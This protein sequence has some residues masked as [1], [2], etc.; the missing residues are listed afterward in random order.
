VRFAVPL[1]AVGG[2]LLRLWGLTR[3]SIWVDEQFTLKFAGMEHPLTWE[4]VLVNLQGPLHAVLLHLWCGL[5]GWGELSVRLPQAILSAACVP[6]LFV[7]A[8][9]TFGNRRAFAAALLLAVNPFHIWY[10]QEVRNYT[11][12]ILF[13]ILGLAVVQRLDASPAPRRRIPELAGVWIGGVLSNL[14]FVFHIAASGLWG[15]V[16][17]RRRSPALVAVVLAAAITLVACLP[18]MVQFYERRIVASHLFRLSSVPASERIRG[19]TTAPIWGLPYAAYAFS[20]GFSLGPSLRELR[21]TPSLEIIRSHPAAILATAL[22]FG[23][24]AA[25]GVARWLRGDARVR[26]WMLALVLPVVLAYL[27]AARNVKVFNPR[28]ASAALPAYILLLVDGAC[29]LNPRR[30]GAVLFA[31]VLALSAISV[32]QLQTQPRFWKEDTRSTAAVLRAE[33]KP[34]DLVFMIGGWDPIARYYWT[35][36]RDEP[37]LRHYF[38]PYRVPPEQSPSDA[39]KALEEIRSAKRT[40]VVLCRDDFEDPQGKWEAFLRERFEVERRWE[41]PGSRV[42]KLGAERAP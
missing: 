29:A 31:G 39:A 15:L 13:A 21:K 14:S 42:W 12:V 28:Y 8:R 23:V 37:S 7:A 20:T 5:F 2:L 17:F 34:G 33:V 16:R 40:Y 26:L 30:T 1:L 27:A 10:A 24:L 9:P 18:W 25:A 6:L 4:G 32:Y 41:F 36:L 22:F 3:Q 35:A 38:P 19:E 11:L